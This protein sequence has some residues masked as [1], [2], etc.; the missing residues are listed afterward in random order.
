MKSKIVVFSGSTRAGSF[1]EKLAALAAANLAA[2]GAEVTHISLKDYPLSFVDG[3]GFGNHPKEAL[4]LRELFDAHHGMFIACPEYN[5]GYPALLKNALDWAS[6]AIPVAPGTSLSGKVIALGAASPGP[7][8][9]YRA[10][11]QLRTSLELGF[12]ATLVP[13]MV[14]VGNYGAAF[15]E[16]G[17]LSDER[18]AGFLSATLATLVSM[19][20]K[21]NA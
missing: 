1:N 13:S 10:L 20:G 16:D 3:A 12:G 8:G 5:A 17:S 19:T 11:T 15:K 6:V 9:G 7:M 18:T 4:A 14:A 2:L 21:L